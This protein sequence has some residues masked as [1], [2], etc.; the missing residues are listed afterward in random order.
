[1]AEQSE[2]REFRVPQP[3]TVVE[4]LAWTRGPC[5]LPSP[6]ELDGIAIVHIPLRLHGDADEFE[7]VLNHVRRFMALI[8]V[9]RVVFEIV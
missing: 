4:L 1:M 9:E 5:S 7:R 6:S 3:L 8:G 2:K